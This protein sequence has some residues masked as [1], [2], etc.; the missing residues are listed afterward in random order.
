MDTGVDI[1]WHQDLAGKWRGGSNSWFDPYGQ[2]P[3]TPTDLNGHGTQTMG[4]MVGGEHAGTAFGVAPG[5]QWIAAK[6]FK[7]D[8]KNLS[9]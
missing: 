1:N 6:I 7:D 5:V 8:G 4:V 2:H 3:T 9:C